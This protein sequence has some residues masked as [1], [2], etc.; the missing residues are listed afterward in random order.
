MPDRR[1]RAGGL[2]ARR[3][4][5]GRPA[6]PGRHGVLLPLARRPGAWSAFYPSPMGAT[7][8]LLELDAWAELEA[9]QPGAARRSSPTWRRCSSTARAG[10]ASTGSSRSTTATSW[11]A[12]IRTRWRGLTG[13]RRCGRRSTAFFDDLAALSPAGKEAAWQ[14]SRQARR[15][16]D[17]PSHIAGHPAGQREGSYEKHGRAPARRALAR[18][19]RSTGINPGPRAHRPADA[20]PARPRSGRPRRYAAPL[21][22]DDLADPRP[23]RRLRAVIRQDGRLDDVGARRTDRRGRQR[24]ALRFAVEGAE[25]LR[26]PRCRRSASRCAS[27]RAARR[28]ARSC[29][30]PRC[31]SRPRSAATTR[32]SRSGSPSCS[33]PAARW[34]E[35]LRSLLWTNVTLVVPRVRRRTTVALS[36]AVHLRLRGDRGASTSPALRDGEVPLELLFSGTVFYA[37][38]RAPAGRRGSRGTAR[39]R[40]GCRWRLARGDGPALP[41]QR[42]AAARARGLRPPRRLQGPAR[43]C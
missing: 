29:S 12:L 1:L 17:A 34:G 42:L 40:T 26:P 25:A 36:H 21:A 43:R 19:E 23:P 33:A 39:P 41:R 13:G 16:T 27:T 31:A 28:S 4:H 2:R 10:C 38:E 9:R 14:K 7:E 18:R 37:D 8:S 15:R 32:P 6:D 22:A 20:E 24:P 5:V 3:R 11:S 30:R 35:T